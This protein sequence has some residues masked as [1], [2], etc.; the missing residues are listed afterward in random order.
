MDEGNRGSILQVADRWTR[1]AAIALSRRRFLRRTL[2]A[3]FATIALRFGFDA[4]PV[5]AQ[6]GCIECCEPGCITCTDCPENL[7]CCSQG[8]WCYYGG[9]CVCGGYQNCGCYTAS[10][11]VVACD[12]N[13]AYNDCPT[14]FL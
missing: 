6:S 13:Y 7:Y 9:C 14:C 10:I 1:D 5:W 12:D 3:G 4:I 8:G 2:G 11:C